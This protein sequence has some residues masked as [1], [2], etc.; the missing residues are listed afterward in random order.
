MLTPVKLIVGI[1]VIAALVYVA[2]M[3]DLPYRNKVT[4]VTDFASCVAAGNPVMKSYPAQCSYNGKTY[5]EVISGG[6]TEAE[7][8][9]VSTP[10]AGSTISSP[11]SVSGQARGGWYFEASFP[12]Q[13]LDANGKVIGE[14]PAQA[15]GEWMTSEF[16]PFSASISFTKPTT[17]TGI[18][19]FKND[20]PSG[21]PE[22]DR[23]VDVPVM[24]KT[25]TTTGTT[26]KACFASGCSGQVCSD[27]M[28]VSTCMYRPEYACYKQAK[29]ERQATGECGWTP[30]P[31]FNACLANPP[32]E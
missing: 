14:G 30:T 11:L 24:F 29:C 32:Q 6:S 19:R 20:N 2:F 25:A 26:V 7:M 22:N 21:L 13:I 15:Q 27:E 16:V 8:I 3:F 28:V 1:I 18:V 5:T 4:Q 9:R 12:V 31:A 10:A 23:H 17:A